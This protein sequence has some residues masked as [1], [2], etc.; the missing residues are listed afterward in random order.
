M[1]PLVGIA[2]DGAD[3]WRLKIYLQFHD[4]A[5]DAAWRI[6]RRLV[7]RADLHRL[8]AGQRLHLLGIDLGPHGI[9]GAKL[10]VRHP[11]VAI[12]DVSHLAGPVTL[13]DD[14]AAA[15]RT[16]LRN[17]LVIHRLRRPDDPALA[18]PAEVDF[19]LG[20][21]ELLWD[22]LETTAALRALRGPSAPVT[23][24][25]AEFG[26]AVRRVGAGRPRRQGQRLLR[27]DRGRRGGSGRG[28]TRRV[29]R[30]QTSAGVSFISGTG[31]GPGVTSPAGCPAAAAGWRRRCP[32][33][34]APGPRRRG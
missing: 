31:G 25:A 13:L 21:N 29:D 24:L 19:A 7:G 8:F 6:A 22:D 28:L 11:E 4:D 14:L 18:T 3:A 32:S 9:A 33:P 20:E 23:E 12:R 5:G 10:Y 15:G 16:H 30:R 34:S 26:I 17:L 1:L 2:Y 27:A